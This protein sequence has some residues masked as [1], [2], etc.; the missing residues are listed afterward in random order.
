MERSIRLLKYEAIYTARSKSDVKFYE[1][2]DVQPFV[3]LA[4][5]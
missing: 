2:A 5:T 1:V 3:T 4:E